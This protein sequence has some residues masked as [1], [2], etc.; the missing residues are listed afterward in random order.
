MQFRARTQHHA[1]TA[2]L[3]VSGHNCQDSTAADEMQLQDPNGQDGQNAG[4]KKPR[5]MKFC[6]HMLVIKG[7][8]VLFQHASLVIKGKPEHTSQI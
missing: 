8:L 7:S 6:N 4:E 5:R 2:Q 1:G 3:I